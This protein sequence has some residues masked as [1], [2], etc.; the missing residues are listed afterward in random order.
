MHGT[1]IISVEAISQQEEER[2][3]EPE[4]ERKKERRKT[5]RA[6][7]QVNESL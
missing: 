3:I 5:T 7:W 1:R 4:K 2:S 6:S